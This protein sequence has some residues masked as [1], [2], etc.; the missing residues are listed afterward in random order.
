MFGLSVMEIALILGVI[1]LVVGP[2]VVGRFVGK[3]LVTIR[4]GAVDLS[5]QI[6]QGLEQPKLPP[7]TDKQ[8]PASDSKK[9]S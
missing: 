6:V 5:D 3:S 2:A 4:K 9:D 1:T 7:P 8:D